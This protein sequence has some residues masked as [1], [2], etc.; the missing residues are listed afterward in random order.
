MSRHSTDDALLGFKF[1]PLS[2]NDDFLL[3]F[4]RIASLARTCTRILKILPGA[5][6]LRA[7]ITHEIVC[8]DVGL[9]SDILVTTIHSPLSDFSLRFDA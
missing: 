8:V 4:L 2:V 3:D 1:L 6:F 7:Q 9:V 5:R